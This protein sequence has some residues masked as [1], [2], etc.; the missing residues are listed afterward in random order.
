MKHY[1]KIFVIVLAIGLIFTSVGLP[2]GAQGGIRDGSTSQVDGQTLQGAGTNT[3]VPGG[4]GFIMVH[5]TA[6][7]PVISSFEYGFAG[8][9]FLYNPGSTPAYYEAAVNL[10][11]G[12]KI[13]KVVLYYYDNSTENIWVTLAAMGMDEFDLPNLT[14]LTTSG[15]V[16]N[17][18]VMEDTTIT[19][20]TINNQSYTYWIEAGIPGS[21]STNLMIRGIRIDYSYPVNLPLINK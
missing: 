7:I 9:G 1:L 20:D 11:H 6:F 21:Q 3:A 19:P 15:A 12:A 14:N 10:P 13:T 18:R 8:G 2:V 5:P 17:H 16:E 4:P